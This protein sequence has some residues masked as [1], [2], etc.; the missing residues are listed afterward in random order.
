V[1]VYVIPLGP[2]RY[3]LYC[4]SA[5]EVEAEP[6]PA[7]PDG[8]L[9]TRLKNRFTV[10]LREAEARRH[11]PE[12]VVAGEKSWATRAQ[13]RVM[14]WVAE[15]IAEQRLLWNLRNETEVTVAH[16]ADLT[17]DQ[18]HTVINRVLQRDRDRHLRWLIVDSLLAIASGALAIL[19]GPNFVF[20]YFAFRLVGHWFSMQGANQGLKHIAWIG[21][22]CPPLSELREVGILHGSARAERIGDISERLHLK[23]LSTFYERVAI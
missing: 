3:E 12:P 4:E 5:A 19:P 17:F 16:P 1:E 23:H 9:F 18:V 8:G 21:R 11:D 6:Q 7:Y 2:E 13:E 10:M 20:Y 15:R 14:A 22:S